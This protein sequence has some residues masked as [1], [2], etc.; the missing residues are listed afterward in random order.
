MASIA[1][2]RAELFSG[3]LKLLDL[4]TFRTIFEHVQYGM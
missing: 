3:L 2:M 1:D 4:R